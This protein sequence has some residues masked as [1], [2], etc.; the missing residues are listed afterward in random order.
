MV[1]LSLKKLRERMRTQMIRSNKRE[2]IMQRKIMKKSWMRRSQ[3]LV[4]LKINP[5]YRNQRWIQ[6][7]QV[8]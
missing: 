8:T 4:T 1:K 7:S 2:K 3:N 6:I 5:R